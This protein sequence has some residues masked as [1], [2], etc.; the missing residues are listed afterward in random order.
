MTVKRLRVCWAS[1]KAR[2]ASARLA[3]SPD[4]MLLAL[5]RGDGTASIWDVASAKE[6]GAVRA[7]GGGLRSVAFSGD[8]RGLATG[9]L[10]RCPATLECGAGAGLRVACRALKECSWT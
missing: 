6:L 5:A 1:V 9:G 10:G 7:Q 4:G 8:G 2:A 3:F